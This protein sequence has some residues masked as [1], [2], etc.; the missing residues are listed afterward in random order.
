MARMDMDWNMKKGGGGGGGKLFSSFNARP[1]K[2]TQ[3]NIMVG[4]PW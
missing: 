4:V 3:K 2:L 1:A